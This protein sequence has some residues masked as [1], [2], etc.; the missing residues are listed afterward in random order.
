[1]DLAPVLR[2]GRFCLGVIAWRK[3]VEQRFQCI[4]ALLNRSILRLFFLPQAEFRFPGVQPGGLLP[5]FRNMQ[6]QR[7]QGVFQCLTRS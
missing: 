5:L 6:R 7:E 1:M 3:R 2:N 4:N